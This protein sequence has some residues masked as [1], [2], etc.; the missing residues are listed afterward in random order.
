MFDD[1]RWGHAENNGT[2]SV[3]SI[4][5]RNVYIRFPV[6][7]TGVLLRVYGAEM[8]IGDG[9]Y[10]RMLDVT[11]AQGIETMSRYEMNDLRQEYQHNMEV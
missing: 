3:G 5:G 1:V 11:A 6:W 4:S 8:K 2:V 9:R 10:L 7:Y